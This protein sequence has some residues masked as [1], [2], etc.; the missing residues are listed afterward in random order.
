[1]PH[2]LTS[3]LKTLTCR[4]QPELSPEPSFW[5]IWLPWP[6]ETTTATSSCH[7]WSKEQRWRQAEWDSCWRSFV[8]GFETFL[9]TKMNVWSE[10]RPYR[11]PPPN[12]PRLLKLMVEGITC[13]GRN[14]ENDWS[15]RCHFGLSFAFMHGWVAHVIY[16]IYSCSNTLSLILLLCRMQT[17]DQIG[18]L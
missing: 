6:G 11:R 15:N 7:P 17:L 4:S 16:T 10:V 9:K 18:V 5:M 1:M 13:N 3:R 2:E 12:C 8:K 14:W